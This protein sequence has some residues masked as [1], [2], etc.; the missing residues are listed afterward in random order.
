LGAALTSAGIASIEIPQN[1][2]QILQKRSAKRFRA[3]ESFCK[4]NSSVL[5][6][7]K[8]TGL[9]CAGPGHLKG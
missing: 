5:Q 1:V 8:K 2:L 3:A 6:N 7:A 9:R 4:D